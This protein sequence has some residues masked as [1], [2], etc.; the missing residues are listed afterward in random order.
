M[1]TKVCK[2]QSYLLGY[3]Y[4]NNFCEFLSWNLVTFL[5]VI[6]VA[7]NLEMYHHIGTISKSPN[8]V[9]NRL[10]KKVIFT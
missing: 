8:K 2:K 5:L 10:D 7:I 4:W 6:F 3:V 9:S 1:P